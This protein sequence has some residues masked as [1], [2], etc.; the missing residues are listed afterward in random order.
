MV[1]PNTDRS[2][3]GNIEAGNISNEN[4]ERRADMSGK[5][6]F[7]EAQAF[8]GPAPETINGRLVRILCAV[9]KKLDVSFLVNFAWYPL[10]AYSCAPGVLNIA[11]MWAF[12]PTTVVITLWYC[13]KALNLI[14]LSVMCNN[15][16]Y[17]VCSCKCVTWGHRL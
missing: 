9:Q 12:S 14:T 11:C 7:P 16:T 6:S 13:P 4:A 8:D 10:S 3:I 2:K 17:N 5:P 15:K 1:T